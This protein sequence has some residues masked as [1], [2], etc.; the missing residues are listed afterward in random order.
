M[1]AVGRDILYFEN[2]S[3][4]SNKYPDCGDRV[5]FCELIIKIS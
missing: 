1:F 3:N 5:I 4:Y 2:S